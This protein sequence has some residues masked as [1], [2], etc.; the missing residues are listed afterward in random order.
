MQI[1]SNISIKKYNTFGIDIKAKKLVYIY[2]PDEL[3]SI[4]N[5]IDLSQDILVLGEGSNIL[6][7]KNFDGVILKNNIKGIEHID[8][9]KNFTEL[10]VGAGVNWDSF[11]QYCI[12]NNI[13]GLENLSLIPGTVGASPVQNIGAYGVEVKDFISKVEY[14]NLNNK[15]FETI[16]AKE[17]EFGYRSSIFKTLFKDKSIITY[18]YYR[19]PKKYEF[20]I[21]YGSLKTE[22]KKYKSVNA[23]NIRKSVISIRES[24]LP[25]YEQ[26]GNA[27]SFFK[28]PI[29]D[30]NAAL[31][32]KQKYDD[33]PLYKIDDK[34]V[35]IAAGWLID[36]CGW[37]GKRFGDAGVHKYQALVIVNYKNATG[38]EIYDLSKKIQQTVFEKFN[39]K[40]QPEVNIY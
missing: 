12:N 23:K 3:I 22:L 33:I 40:I 7:T 30:I 32:I 14:L 39:I 36:K 25:D 13:G 38:L 35:K 15:T 24:K 9:N 11:V 5:D 31:D 20:K 2:I 27:G 8:E 26:L 10:K 16:D 6:F 17:C 37:K 18:V 1:Y 21:N 28:N 4:L 29:I 34:F 19:I